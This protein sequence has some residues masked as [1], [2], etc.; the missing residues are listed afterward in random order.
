MKLLLPHSYKKIGVFI[1]PLGLIIWICMQ[2]GFITKALYF[3]FGENKHESLYHTVNV[4]IAFVAF[5]S[6]LGGIYFISFSKEKIEDEMVEHTRLVSF[7]FAA[8]AQLICIIIGF[9]LMLLLGEPN[10]G[11]L[12][13]F[14]IA[15]LFLFWLCFICRFNYTLHIKHRYEK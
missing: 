8:L 6:F 9:I 11:G 7:Q 5:F 2:M 12:M 4:I 13:L 15:I 3:L 10:D 14:F 1:A